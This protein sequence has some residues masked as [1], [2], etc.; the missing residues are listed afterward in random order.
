MKR[1]KNIA[2]IYE[3]DQPTLER[4]ALL[5][6]D[7]G[8]RLTIVHPIKEIPAGWE[9]LIVG[10]K[11]VDVRKLVLREHEARLKEVAKYVRSL[12]VRPETRLLIGEPFL[13]I[14]RDVIEHQRDLVIMTA[15]GKGGVK[16]R[17]FGS[18]SRRLMRKC[19]APV[20]VLKPARKKHFQQILAAIDP[21]V[22][23]DTHDTLN[24][25][26]LELASSLAARER[27]DLHIVHAWKVIGESL[28]RKRGGRYA[29]EVN[30]HVHQ[31]A[32]RRRMLVKNLLARHSVTGYQ[33]HLLKGDASIV[34]PPLVTKLDIDVLVIGTVCRTG[35]PGFII[36]NTAE[37]VLDAV[38]CSV[39]TVKPDGFVSP[40]APLIAAAGGQQEMVLETG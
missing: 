32:K 18:T 13:E 8:A 27:A 31:E 36:G 40:V 21:E 34:I 17:L 33:L 3:C 14:I 35:I 15:E 10:Q 19:P 28:L 38:D 39:F 23:G 1:F 22:T 26:I 2:L 7:N 24:D 4:A 37:V 29:A 5:A 16:E 12:G 9:R 25:V 20:L 6:K 30:R 11:P